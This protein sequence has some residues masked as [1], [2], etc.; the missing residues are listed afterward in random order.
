M[1]QRQPTCQLAVF[2]GSLPL[3]SLGKRGNLFLASMWQLFGPAAPLL[4]LSSLSLLQTLS[5]LSVMPLP[6]TG[7]SGWIMLQRLCFLFYS[8]LSFLAPHFQSPTLGC[9]KIISVKEKRMF[10]SI[11][12]VTQL[13]N[14]F[15][16][17]PTMPP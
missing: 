17:D 5:F 9:T 4:P 15:P 16:E 6:H 2:Q 10:N 1:V 3:T 11:P 12:K 8:N 7:L 13:I 14:H